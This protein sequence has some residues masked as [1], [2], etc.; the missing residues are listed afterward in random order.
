MSQDHPSAEVVDRV[1]DL[2]KARIGLRPDPFL[3]SRLGRSIRDEAALQKKDV[4][5]YLQTL[6]VTEGALQSLLNRVT[7]QE[8]GFFRH[9]EHFLMLVSDVLPTLPR[10]IRIWSAGC[11]NGQEAF[12]LAMLLEEHRIDGSVIATDL[13]TQA[14]E[15]T[16]AAC[17]ATRELTGLS[18]ERIARHLTETGAGWQINGAVRDRV[19]TMRHNLMSPLPDRVR[20]SHVVF[21]RNVLIYFSAEHTKAILDRVADTMPTAWVFLGAAETM[22]TVSDRFETIR[23]GDAYAYRP[24]VA[25]TIPTQTA[26]GSRVD[27]RET[28]SRE[29]SSREVST[30]APLRA[31]TK[32]RPAAVAVPNTA[33]R[34][35]RL[36]ISPP[37]LRTGADDSAVTL[38]ARSGQQ[39]EAEG[40]HL[41]AVVHF[42]K[43][44]YLAH[45]DALAHLH[46]GLALEAAGD[47][48]SAQ[49]AFGAARRALQEADD[50]HVEH[51]L[52]GYA[53]AELM[54]LLDAKQQELTP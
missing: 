33:T 27:R 37:A 39:A 23:I 11:A 9:P 6:F 50:A 52:G 17:Y 25:T 35:A 43:W 53:P 31:R 26:Q 41:A 42:R 47:H 54:R 2:L 7:V 1:A 15:R 48:P 29:V 24:R 8:T 19:S 10:P 45:D 20:S 51:A 40:D 38:L 3:R 18:P 4:E 16:N 5:D 44:A 34:P 46:L 13:S 21:C 30:V 14:L 22:W 12:T 36:P 28:S 49:R 32:S